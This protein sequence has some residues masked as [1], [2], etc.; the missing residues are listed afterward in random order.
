MSENNTSSK[1]IKCDVDACKFNNCE[2]GYC[3]LDSISV[4]CTCDSDECKNC[5]E[6]ICASFATKGGPIT[7]NEYE[8]QSEIS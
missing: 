8:V 3:E 2:E 4:S 5:E 6:T 1:N 7:D